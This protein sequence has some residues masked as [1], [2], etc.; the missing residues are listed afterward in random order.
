VELFEAAQ[1]IFDDGEGIEMNK[2][3]AARYSQLSA[4]QGNA[5]A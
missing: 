5:D 3:L 1:K 4:D 2:F